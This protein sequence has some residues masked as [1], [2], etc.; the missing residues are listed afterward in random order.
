MSPTAGKG[1]LWRALQENP[2]VSEDQ[3]CLL[4]LMAVCPDSLPFGEASSS[5]LFRESHVWTVLPRL[6]S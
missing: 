1:Q 5:P 6:C 4:T 3:P 2:Q